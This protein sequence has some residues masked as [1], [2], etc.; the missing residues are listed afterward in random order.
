MSEY[1]KIK[2]ETL[3]DIADAVREK[4]GSTG[5]MLATDFA[6]AIRGIT[7]IEDLT[8]E[9]TEYA[10]LN[11]ELEEVINSL[12]EAGGSGG[13]VET[14]TVTISGEVSSRYPVNIAYT[15]VSSDGKVVGASQTCSTSSA[16]VTCVKGTIVTVLYKSNLN[17]TT[18]PT[19]ASV[20]FSNV[21][22]G[23]YKLTDGADTAYIF[24][25]YNNSGG[26][27]L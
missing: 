13:S 12:P 5:G 2:G 9:L 15:T 21:T 10:S 8:A 22:M 20:L 18:S 25:D 17:I 1:Y 6:P 24:N 16:T 14:C 23:V 11:A 4:T 27:I 19:N 7:G 26:S 3:T